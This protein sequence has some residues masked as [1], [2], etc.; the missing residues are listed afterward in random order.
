MGTGTCLCEAR[1][2]GNER[3]EIIQRLGM[4]VGGLM[5]TSPNEG[6]RDRRFGLQ[7]DDGSFKM[8]HGADGAGGLGVLE[9]PSPHRQSHAFLRLKDCI[10]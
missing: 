3:K 10:K 2:P 8:L 7:S 6:G 5:R 9:K 1:S 4:S